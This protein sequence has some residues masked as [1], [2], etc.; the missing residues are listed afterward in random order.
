MGEAA[1]R[2]PLPRPSGAVFTV[3]SL[4]KC[5]RG[6]SRAKVKIEK[7]QGNG[8]MEGWSDYED[9]NDYE[10]ASGPNWPNDSVHHCSHPEGT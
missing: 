8:V 2:T 5:E 1:V 7:S 9:E 10:D 6:I 3:A 4:H